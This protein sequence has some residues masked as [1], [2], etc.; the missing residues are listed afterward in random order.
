MEGKKDADD[1]GCEEGKKNELRRHKQY[2]EEP[3]TH[4]TIF[5][6]GRLRLLRINPRGQNT[7][8]G[9]YAT[10]FIVHRSFE[11]A[12]KNRLISGHHCSLFRDFML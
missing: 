1:I 7:V 11:C 12:Y 2:I 6:F 3:D 9:S 10:V 8:F 4:Y 5:V